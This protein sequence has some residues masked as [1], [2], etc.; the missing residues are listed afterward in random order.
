MPPDTPCPS[1]EALRRSLDPDDP[2]PEAERRRIEAH[3]D[4]CTQGCKL[5]IDVLLRGNTLLVGPG[6]AAAGN[7]PGAECP[8]HVGRYQITAHSA[9]APSG[10]LLDAARL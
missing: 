5:A 2:M 8:A 6:T 3:V 7:A 9:R 4:C 10:R 1:A